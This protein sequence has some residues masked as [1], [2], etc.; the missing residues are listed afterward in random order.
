MLNS[1]IWMIYNK[2]FYFKYLQKTCKKQW[3]GLEREL[4]DIGY[5]NPHRIL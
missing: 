3:E 4:I 2:I 1:H 5:N